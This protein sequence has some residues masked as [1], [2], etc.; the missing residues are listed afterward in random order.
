ML[1]QLGCCQ[2]AGSSLSRP[3]VN[4]E[5]AMQVQTGYT[6]CSK[7]TAFC[8]LKAL[9]AFFM[10]SARNPHRTFLPQ[11]KFPIFVNLKVFII[12]VEKQKPAVRSSEIS[13]K[14]HTSGNADEIP[15]KCGTVHLPVF[16]P[17]QTVDLSRSS[18]QS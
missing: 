14:P 4:E 7:E 11:E 3:A 6:S 9:F 8:C 18:P 16:R 13:V 10:C 2:L 12:Q 17:H 5:A 15:G 1:W